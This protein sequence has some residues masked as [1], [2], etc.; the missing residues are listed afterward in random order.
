MVNSQ[1]SMDELMSSRFSNG[2]LYQNQYVKRLR[3]IPN[4][5]ER[6]GFIWLRFPHH[7]P[8][9]K[10]V[11]AGV[12]TGQEPGDRSWCRGHRKM[13]LTVLLRMAS[14]ACFPTEPRTTGVSL[15]E[16]LL[17]DLFSL[18][19]VG[20]LVCSISVAEHINAHTHRPV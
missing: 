18:C 11:R 17:S 12:Q 14:S 9:L 2:F 20:I 13:L 6:K 7:H 4:I 8:L 15:I 16:G 5:L 1:S 3:E 19:H 10:T